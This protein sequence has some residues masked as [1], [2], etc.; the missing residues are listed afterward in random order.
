MV[1]MS[2]LE[3]STPQDDQSLVLQSILSEMKALSANVN[4]ISGHVD[5]LS[6]TVHG[7]SSSR[8]RPAEAGVSSWADR[9]T[10]VLVVAFKRRPGGLRRA[11][12]RDYLIVRA[13]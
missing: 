11:S 8:K 3:D 13:Q 1:I 9:S 2:D 12:I 10:G 4:S 7:P 6:E 5:S